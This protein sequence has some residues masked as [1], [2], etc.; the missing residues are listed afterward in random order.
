M[1]RLALAI[2]LCALAPSLARALPPGE[3]GARLR[4]A[5]IAID[6]VR[7]EEAEPII[8]SLA[9]AY[10]GDPDVRWERAM[11]RFV[12]GDYAGA[13][14]DGAASMVRATRLRSAE[15][16]VEIYRLMWATRSSAERSRVARTTEAAP[17]RAA[18][19]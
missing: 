16:R 18:P 17:S 4:E 11:L 8:E 19:A 7:I 12:R 3:D 6:E 9:T 5:A 2:T 1:R 13:A 15:E 10:P 14:R